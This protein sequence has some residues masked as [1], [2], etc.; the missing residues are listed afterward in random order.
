ML[1]SSGK[2]AHVSPLIPSL[3]LRVANLAVLQVQ[4]KHQGLPEAI[5][6]P[7]AFSSSGSSSPWCRF[8][9]QILKSEFTAMFYLVS[10]TAKPLCNSCLWHELVV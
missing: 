6:K 8:A 7:P 3:S 4:S 1:S 2:L 5:S 10:Q 9:V